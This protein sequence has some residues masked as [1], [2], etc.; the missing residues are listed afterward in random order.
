ML[1]G[2]DGKSSKAIVDTYETAVKKFGIKIAEMI[3]TLPDPTDW[4]II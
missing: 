4:Q 2:S 1:Y 3:P